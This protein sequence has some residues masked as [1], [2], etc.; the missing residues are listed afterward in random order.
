MTASWID[1]PEAPD[2]TRQCADADRLLAWIGLAFAVIIIGLDLFLDEAKSSLPFVVPTIAAAAFL[3]LRH[4]GRV[5][6]RLFMGAG[7]MI[8][9]GALIHEVGGMIEMHFSI[10][11]FLAFLLVY[12]D[13]RPIVVAAAVIAVHHFAFAHAQHAGLPV[14]LMPQDTVDTMS[15][16]SIYGITLIH[17]IFVIIQTAVL[18]V[19]AVRL[20]NE[21]NLVGLGAQQMALIAADMGRGLFRERPELAASMKGSLAHS[22]DQMRQSL[23]K[24]FAAVAHVTSEIAHGR[25]ASRVATAG[26]EGDLLELASNVNTSVTRLEEVLKGASAALDALSAGQ[27]IKALATASDGGEFDRMAQSVNRLAGF[28]DQLI[29]TQKTVVDAIAAGRFDTTSSL[30]GLSGF[31]RELINGLNGVTVQVGGMIG[32]LRAV[33]EAM[34]AGDLRVRMSGTYRGEL[35]D[36]QRSVADALDSLSRMIEEIS[37]AS[38]QIATAAAEIAAGSQDISA[39]TEQ[40][41][42]SLEETAASMEELT[43]TVRQNAEGAKTASRLATEAAGIATRGGDA[44]GRMV[45]TM[46]AIQESSQKVGDI[47]TVIDGIAFQTN[48]LALNAAV[49]AARAGEQGRGFA[50]VATEVRSL[51]Q[52]S[53]A[54]A[55]EIKTLIGESASRVDQGAALVAEAGDTIGAV[56]RSVQQVTAIMAEISAASA[57]QSTGIEQV[58]LTITHMDEATQRNAALV[59]EAAAAAMAVDE[60]AVRLTRA[61]AVFN[62]SREP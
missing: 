41:A 43:S 40:Q 36:L 61:V 21:A 13:W 5:L 25:L 30:E 1:L 60:Q 28:I 35:A 59:E 38:G 24:Q 44:V 26:L 58:N 46:S 19:I 45:G 10:F 39:R 17:A 22:V 62:P 54:A 55:K 9:S 57:E 18:C 37:A 48:I 11:V 47:I 51:A 56:V 2:L 52:R 7:F 29:D 6:T 4:A 14:R 32:E 33:M 53:A 12:R 15:L 42:A 31:Q 50:V 27:R 16:W 34:A 8:L 3:V 20:R 23:K 49:E